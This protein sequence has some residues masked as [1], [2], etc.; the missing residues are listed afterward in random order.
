MG[1]MFRGKDMSLGQLIVP[2][3]IA[4]ET[5]ERIGK[6]GIIQFIDLNDNLASFDR[7]FINE[8]KRCE[9]IE[10]IIRIFEETISFEE[11]RD[12]FNKIFKRNSLAVDLLPIA[13]ADAQ[14]SELSSEQLILKIRTFDNDLKQLT[15]DVAA[16][17]R[18]VS[19]IHEA[20]SLSEHINELIGQDIDQTTAQ[21][22][23][24]L[25]GTIDTSKWEALRMVIWRV[26]RG[27]VVTRSAPIDNRKT[28]FVVF[29]QGDEV[30]NKLNQ[31]CLTSSA[32]I[33]DSMP[34]DVIERI[35]YVNEKRQELN[36]L[37]EVL[38]GALEAKRQ[39]LRL[40][41]SDINIWNEV[42]ERERQV[43]FTLNMFYVDEGHS[44]LCG[45][46]W[47]PTD[48]FSEINRAL[49]EI[50]GPVKPLFGVIQPHPN[51]IPPTYIPTTSFSQCSQDLCDSYSIPKYGEVNPGFLYIITFPFLFG[52]MFGDIGHGIIVFL[53]ALLMI[54]FQKKI[55]LTKR[56]EIFDMLFG[57]RWMILLMGLFSIY[58]G[59]LYNEFFGIAIDLFGTSWNKENGL[60]YE[61]S[62]PNYVYPFGVDPIWKS[63]NNE[64]YFYN[65][66]KMKMSILI[67]VTHMTIG[68]WISLINHIHYKNL[69][70]VVFQFL[71]E[72]IFMSCTF[73]YLC[74]LILIK[75]MFFIEDAPMITNVFLEMFQNFG[76]VT[77]P[78]HMFWGQSFI[79]P[80]LFIFTVL[81][82]I[83]MMVPKPILLYVLKKKDQKRSE[84]GQGQD[85][86]YQ[87]FNQENNDFI[88]ED[89]RQE[90]NDIPYLPNENDGYI[91]ANN[92]IEE[93]QEQFENEDRV[94]L[95]GNENKSIKK[96]NLLSEESKISKILKLIKKKNPNYTFDE[97]E[98]IRV[99][100]DP[101]DENGNNLLEI[102]IFN[103]IHAV[104]FILGCISN[105]AS[106][107]RLWALSLAHAQLGSVFLEYV[108]YTLLEFNN[109]FLTFVGFA[110]F[111]LITL[112]ILIGMESL[113]A[114]LHTLRLHWV[115]FQNKFY[116]GDGIKFVPFKLSTNKKLFN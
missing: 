22:L 67:G 75:W 112:G 58:C 104:E 86:Y 52:V 91:V 40:I 102:I 85:N 5:I 66:L 55:E 29:I 43:Y 88:T 16:A 30:L 78:N 45:E 13:T 98:W 103:T 84:N 114:F 19:G 26:S 2:S 80:I 93:M 116:L 83:A 6:L 65:S 70:N 10:R 47:F 107:L 97:K 12:G 37:T 54:I 87:P 24:Y 73:G 90:N 61:R 74:F 63:S 1:E 109:F 46:G 9:E 68:I 94:S 36:E 33:F 111:A 20:I 113:S 81:S 96:E 115:E 44:H 59:A 32:R 42:I 39:C 28:G 95:L 100:Y 34:I 18:A 11:S 79:E 23:K 41:A 105:T 72:I 62:N 57:A 8:I 17:E 53:F 15:S 64:L 48:Q 76:I 49:E 4:I 35:N 108:F 50:E 99:K 92:N 25:I 69:I 56:N 14:Q 71:P 3:N 60:F 106:Y 89:I 31:I 82:V 7:R 110:L 21:T 51:A 101:D 38:N 77:E 27:F